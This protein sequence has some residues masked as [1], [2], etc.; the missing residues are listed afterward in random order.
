MTNFNYFLN[1]FNKLTKRNKVF[2]DVKKSK[3]FNEYVNIALGENKNL[4]SLNEEFVKIIENEKDTLLLFNV[5][6]WD[7]LS[8]VIEQKGDEQQIELFNIIYCLST[9]KVAKNGNHVPQLAKKFAYLLR[10]IMSVSYS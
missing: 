2:N 4:I 5:K 9:K 3:Y 8:K 7:T 6:D 1:L 10:L